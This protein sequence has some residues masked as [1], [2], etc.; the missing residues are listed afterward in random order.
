MHMSGKSRKDERKRTTDEASKSDWMMSKPRSSTCLGI[1]VGET[2][3]LPTRHPALRWRESDSGSCMELGNLSSRWQGRS[4]SGGPT[5]T[6]VP[7][8]GTGAERP[9]VVKKVV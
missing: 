5:R 9:V 3:L 1:S 7:M 6:R 4:P 2:C 8:R